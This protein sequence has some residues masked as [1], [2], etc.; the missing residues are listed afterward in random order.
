MRKSILLMMVLMLIGAGMSGCAQQPKSA[1]AKEA[2]DQSKSM[3][4]V[5][6]QAKYLVGQANAFL[7]SQNFDQAVQTA[8]YVLA[9]VD[10]NSQDAKS[11]LEKA[12]AEM[13][14]MAQ[15]KVEEMKKSM[16][17]FGK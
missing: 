13:K 16:G 15:Q 6:E 12:T 4:T 17:S 8:K 1:N 9:N 11:I 7:N 5:E 10:A 3:K 14:R 2:I